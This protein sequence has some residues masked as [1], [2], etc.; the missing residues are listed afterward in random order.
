MPTGGKN[1]GYKNTKSGSGRLRR[2]QVR[3]CLI[4]IRTNSPTKLLKDGK[5]WRK[6]T[7]YIGAKLG[8]RLD[9]I[10]SLL[11]TT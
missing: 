4:I 5:I 3:Y 1:I 10:A 11:I 2:L 7:P 6:Q 9:P 8:S